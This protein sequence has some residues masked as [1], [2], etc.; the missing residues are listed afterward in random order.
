M[1]GTLYIDGKDAYALYGVFVTEDGYTE[2]PAYPPLRKVESNDWAEEDGIEPDL[3]APALDTR[4]LSI[5]FSSHGTDAGFGSFIELLSNGAYHTFSFQEAEKTYRLRLVDQPD[6]SLAPGLGIFSLR[7]ADD[8]PLEGYIPHEPDSSIKA[9]TGY[10][11]DQ[12]SLADYGISVLQ[13]SE[14]EIS[15]SPAVK[16]NLLQQTASQ[17]GAVYDGQ[18]VFF[19]AKEVK[20]NCLMQ[21]KT[22]TEFWRNHHAFLYHLT[23]PGERMLYVDATGYEYPCY[24]KSCT[25]EKFSPSGKIWFQFSLVLVFTS[26]RAD[27]D[28]CLLASEKEILILT[29]QDDYTINLS[30]YGN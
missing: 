26:F 10:E 19:Q 4:E 2:L 25:V 27:G 24:Y 20:L 15:K 7:F 3:S 29:E 23:R 30:A 6:L 8:F 12:R 5:Q 22:L 18:G 13:G 28:E 1:T 17:S 9:A 14:A 16:K 21:A 11:L